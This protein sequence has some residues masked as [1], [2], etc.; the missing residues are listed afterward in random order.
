MPW[1]GQS[2]DTC[3]A[4]STPLPGMVSERL[5]HFARMSSFQKEARRV[6]AG[7]MRPEEV[8]GLVALFRGLDRDHDGRISLA[9]LKVL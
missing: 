7:L 4:P 3:T 1:L 6:V 9:E 5:Q 8:A 2:S